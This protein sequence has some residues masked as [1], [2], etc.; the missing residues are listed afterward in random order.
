MSFLT[1][2]DSIKFYCSFVVCVCPLCFLVGEKR[3][4]C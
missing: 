2:G 1:A 3:V 4:Y